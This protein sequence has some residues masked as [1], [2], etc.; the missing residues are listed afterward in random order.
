VSSN[1]SRTHGSMLLVSACGFCLLVMWILL[2]IYFS[3]VLLIRNQ[4]ESTAD[5]VA[6]I[7]ACQLNDGNRI[8]QMNNLV[9]RCR[10]LV[11]SSRQNN[12]LSMNMRNDLHHLTTQILSEDRLAA[13]ELD[14]E[15]FRLRN[16]AVDEAT[17]AMKD[18]FAE[19]WTSCKA[20]LPIV[21][22]QNPH[23]DVIRFGS[24]ASVE[25][26]ASALYGIA[27]LASYD[28]SIR[29]FEVAGKLYRGNIN[30]TLPQEDTDLKFYLSS[31]AAPV[32]NYIAP[33]RFVSTSNFVPIT[34]TYLPSAASVT[35]SIELGT[36]T[37]I[38]PEGA[39]NISVTST[40][41]GYGASP[42]R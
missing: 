23:L 37:K 31:L 35:M 29:A 32:N 9:A 42:V 27:E 41:T 34:S 10:Q 25:S 20:I 11:Y 24:I 40:A 36:G 4:L 15:N 3:M 2:G 26:N 22:A 30:A 28:K 13:L 33:A 6:L 21:L 8:G 7:G 17:K 16:I 14:K 38:F 1:A 5:D 19:K 18:A 39:T 12:E